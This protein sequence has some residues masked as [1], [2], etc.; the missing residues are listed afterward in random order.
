MSPVTTPRFARRGAT[1]TDAFG[2]TN[3]AVVKPQAFCD[4]VDQAGTGIRDASARL[5]CYKIRDG[6]AQPGLLPRDAI[7]ANE[8]GTETL[9][10]VKATMLCLPAMEQ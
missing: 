4:A 5:V 1:L 2:T 8:L 10:A 9:T 3:A 7:V 6:A